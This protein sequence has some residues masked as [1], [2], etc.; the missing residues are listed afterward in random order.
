MKPVGLLILVTVFLLAGCQT[1]TKRLSEAD[2]SSAY[3]QC[4]YDAYNQSASKNGTDP[5]AAINIALDLCEADAMNY[6]MV[7]ARQYHDKQM[8]HASH[9]SG[10]YM[11]LI[12]K[13]AKSELLSYV[14]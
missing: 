14:R 6:A 10:T 8:M 13:T 3:Y 4:L 1:A 2:A 5:E 12:E 11:P 7:F 9:A